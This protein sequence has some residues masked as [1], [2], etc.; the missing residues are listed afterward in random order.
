[1]DRDNAQAGDWRLEAGGCG[2]RRPALGTALP[3]RLCVLVLACVPRAFAAEAENAGPSGHPAPVSSTTFNGPAVKVNTQIVSIREVEAVFADSYVLIQDRLRKGELKP[4][5]LGAA[6]RAAWAAALDT[7][8][9]DRIMDQRAD[10]R[11]KDIMRMYLARAGGDLSGERALE[12][13]RREEAD[14]VRR[15]RRELVAAAG[16]EQELA[17]ALKRRG[18]TMREWEAGLSRE[19]FRRDLL[20][21]ELGPTARSPAATRAFYEEHA[22]LFKQPAAWR[23][24]R[25]R[26]AK[27]R[28]KS[29]EVALEAA[30]MVRAKIAGGADFAELAAKVSD[31]PEFAREGGLLAREGKTDLPPGNFPAEEQVAAEL[32]DGGVS[33]PVDG[34]AWYLIVQRAGYR[35]MTV[36]S[37]EEAGERAAALAYAEKLKQKKRELFEKLKDESYIEV[38][39]KDPPPQLLKATLGGA[40]EFLPPEK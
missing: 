22:E 40:G 9:Q 7:A 14:C 28:F 12:Y 37:F 30:K 29:P 26:I 34:G 36:Q 39:Q 8:T 21:L 27:D 13:F 35:P 4:A 1:M 10:R 19:L 33:E 25:I 24:R 20:A 31:D 6:I 15:L 18:Q 23:L 11:R 2:L 3:A 5:E 38:L 16:G 17:Q 32:A